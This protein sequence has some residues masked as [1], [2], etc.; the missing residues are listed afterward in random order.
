MIRSYAK[1]PYNLNY[2]NSNQIYIGPTKKSTQ[3][4]FIVPEHIIYRYAHPKANRQIYEANVSVHQL[5]F[6]ECILCG[7]GGI[8]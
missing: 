6:I 1:L 2:Y 8:V 3:N 5:I 4:C 7:G